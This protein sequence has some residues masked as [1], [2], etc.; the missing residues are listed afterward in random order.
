MGDDFTHV[1]TWQG[2]AYVAFI[3][4]NEPLARYWFEPN[5]ECPEG[6]GLASV[7]VNEQKRRSGYPDTLGVQSRHLV[8]RIEDESFWL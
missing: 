8:D 7:Y 2:M 5:G 6:R 4:D 3:T 1:S